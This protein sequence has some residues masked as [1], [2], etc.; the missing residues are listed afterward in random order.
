MDPARLG[1]RQRHVTVVD[2]DKPN[3]LYS[4]DIPHKIASCVALSHIYQGGTTSR[5]VDLARKISSFEVIFEL[6][7]LWARS[8]GSA[9]T[10]SNLVR[11]NLV[12]IAH[13]RNH[14]KPKTRVNPSGPIFEQA[15]SMHLEHETFVLKLRL[16][17]E[18]LIVD[19]AT[20]S[21]IHVSF[22]KSLLDEI[23][24]D[25][26]DVKERLSRYVALKLRAEIL[27]TAE[28]TDDITNSSTILQD[29][30]QNESNILIKVLDTKSDGGW[31]SVVTLDD[32]LLLQI[33]QIA[34]DDDFEEYHCS[35]EEARLLQSDESG[36][37]TGDDDEDDEGEKMWANDKGVHSVLLPA[38]TLRGTSNSPITSSVERSMSR[39]DFA[40]SVENLRHND[41][42]RIEEELESDY[43]INTPDLLRQTSLEHCTPC[44]SAPVL[45]NKKSFTN[46]IPSLGDEPFMN[47]TPDEPYVS[48][49]KQRLSRLAKQRS[50]PD[51][52]VRK[53]PLFAAISSE[54]RVDGLDYAFRSSDVPTYIKQ[55][56]KF[57]FIKVG[58]VQKFVNM[59][60]DQNENE[61]PLSSSHA[62]RCGSPHRR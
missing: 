38:P 29:L 4:S 52:Q 15:L 13:R 7:S 37:L 5:L 16:P 30:P 35:D 11:Q 25:P 8:S 58:K 6:N 17:L 49:R 56:K 51:I 34:F 57:K 12:Y 27:N 21:D 55:D 9:L 22:K 39:D 32:D 61:T 54:D 60:E 47:F 45:I 3:V 1:S 53:T 62:S 43:E 42:E 19:L 46:A 23:L 24:L 18:S 26:A 50:T 33:K 36:K 40:E 2:P 59:F 20:A 31:A 14:N 28:I 10:P 44:K 48:P 41:R